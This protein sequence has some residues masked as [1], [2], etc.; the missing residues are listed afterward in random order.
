MEQK[1]TADQQTPPPKKPYTTPT[2]VE[3]GNIAKLTQGGP[4]GMNPDFMSGM[5]AMTMG[6][7]L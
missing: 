2:L 7:C 4:S 5:F 1:A 6:M 3:Y